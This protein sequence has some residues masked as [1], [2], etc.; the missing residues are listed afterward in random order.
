[1]TDYLQLKQEAKT[2]L[3]SDDLSQAKVK[4]LQAHEINEHDVD[5]LLCLGI[6]SVK[7]EDMA[8]AKIWLEKAEKLSAEQGLNMPAISYFYLGNIYRQ[9]QIVEKAIDYYQL[10]IA[11]YPHFFLAHILLAGLYMGRKELENAEYH[12]KYALKLQPGD[13]NAYANLAQVYE[14][15]NQVED[16]RNAVNNALKVNK[17]HIGALL[18]LAKIEKREKDYVTANKILNKIIKITDQTT[19]KAMAYIELGQVLDKQK[20]F[21]DAFKA[22]TRGKQLWSNEVANIPF[23]KKE[24]Q[25][26]ILRNT[27]Y[28]ST[29]ISKSD[30]K[31]KSTKY[32]SPVFFVGFPRSGTTLA[33]QI[34]NQHP[35]IVTSDENPFIKAVIGEISMI[36][37][38]DTPYPESIAELNDADL[39]R[40]QQVYWDSVVDEITTFNED[41]ILVDKLP[42]NIIELGLINKIFPDS[43]I[44]VALRDPRDACLS[45]FM[46]GFTPNPAMINFLSMQS[47]VD[48]YS[49]VMGLWL[50]YRELLPMNWH[51]YR[52]EDLVSDFEKTTRDIF[53]FLNLDYPEDASEFYIAAGKRA[54]STPSYQDVA[55]PIYQRSKARW[56]KYEKHFKPYIDKLQPFIDEFDYS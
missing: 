16:G 9:L 6:L 11:T 17:N 30:K 21:D 55:S 42:L 29:R 51:Q 54:I 3:D 18:A 47:S 50:H 10:S 33:E 31:T 56:K 4:F 5:V 25:N 36:I 43:H 20:K 1:M 46:Q 24:Y 7:L 52:Y 40:L 27:E 34:I 49:Q 13:A 37:Q 32:H 35:D 19:A 26:K 12:Y 14:L 8:N 45:G 41:L 28:F 39:Q 15:L 44:L 23:D 2:L 38:S 22:S 48:F 53:I